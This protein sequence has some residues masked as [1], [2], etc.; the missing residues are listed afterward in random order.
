MTTELS[1]HLYITRIDEAKRQLLAAIPHLP[2][3][4]N[5]GMEPTEAMIEAD[6]ALFAAMDRLWPVGE[7]KSE[8]TVDIRNTL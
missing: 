1:E 6:M 3:M 2:A 8:K 7:N 5:R 4:Q